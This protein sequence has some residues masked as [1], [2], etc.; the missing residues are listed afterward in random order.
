MD[1]KPIRILYVESNP[2]DIYLARAMLAEKGTGPLGAAVFTLQTVAQLGEALE[3]IATEMPDLILLDLSLPDGQGLEAFRRLSQAAADVPVL[4]I[5]SLDDEA[6][7]IR[8][9]QEGAQDYLV[10]GYLDSRLLTRAI[11]YARE[12]HRML[13][14]LRAASL[15][16][17]LTG[18]YNRRGFFT[19]ARQHLELARR[20]RQ[21]LALIFIDLDGLKQ[22]NDTYGHAAG[23]RALRQSAAV[24]RA[25]FR[26]SDILARLGGDEFAALAMVSRG[27]DPQAILLR[28]HAHL[29][30]SNAQSTE[31]GSLSMSAGVTVFEPD[32]S[33]SL[34][35]VVTVADSAM[36]ER[37]REKRREASPRMRLYPSF[38]EPAP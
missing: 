2:E 18:L 7:A 16:D 13:I 15:T 11:F 12:R 3:V 35:E 33:L 9:V 4:V 21:L 27:A 25:T 10:K 32:G 37:K 38:G 22:I 1:Q 19:L 20:A 23:D 24:L 8:A 31:P 34:E 30:E 28:L 14:K 36:Y 17:D 6:L 5:S 26:A 29:T